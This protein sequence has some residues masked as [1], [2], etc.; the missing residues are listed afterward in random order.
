MRADVFH[1]HQFL[2]LCFKNLRLHSTQHLCHVPFGSLNLPYFL[3]SKPAT[4]TH[5]YCLG[6]VRTWVLVLHNRNEMNRDT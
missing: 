6:N 3:H 2:N 5:S 1:E 4:G